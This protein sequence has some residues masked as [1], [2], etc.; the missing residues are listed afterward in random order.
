VPLLDNKPELTRATDRLDWII[1]ET[2]RFAR[3]LEV[4]PDLWNPARSIAALSS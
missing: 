1:E 2:G 4:W 3:A